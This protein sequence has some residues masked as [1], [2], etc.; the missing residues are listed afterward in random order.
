MNAVGL[1]TKCIQMKT[2]TNLHY[3]TSSNNV[4]ATNYIFVCHLCIHM[5]VTVKIWLCVYMYIYK[6]VYDDAS[7]WPGTLIVDTHVIRTN[8]RYACY[9][10]THVLHAVYA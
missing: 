2:T 7:A 10:P 6:C 1:K 4:F 9:I 5:H 3:V 8:S